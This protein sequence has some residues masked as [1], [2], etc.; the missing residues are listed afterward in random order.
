MS[1]ENG[2]SV[3]VTL[4]ALSFED[5]QCQRLKEMEKR[6]ED[7]VR[8]K[9]KDWEREVEL[10]RD[11]F[12]LLYP[13]DRVWGSEELLNDPLVRK[14]RGSTDIL[15]VKKMRTLFLEYPDTGRRYKLRFDVTSF[16]SK[17]VKVSTDGDRLIVRAYRTEEGSDGATVEREYSRKI[18]KPKDVDATKLRSF[19]TSD[20][21]LIVEAPVPPHSLNLRKLS[22]SPS[23]SSQGSHASSSRSRSPSNSPRT[24]NIALK[25]NV[26][27]FMDVNGDRRMNL[28]VDVGLIFKPKD[29]T[30]QIIKTNI[31]QVMAKHEERTSEKVSKSK[32]HREYELSEKIEPFTMRAGLMDSGRLLIGAMAKGYF[33][34]SKKEAGEKMAQDLMTKSALACNVLDLASFPP[35]AVAT[36]VNPPEPSGNDSPPPP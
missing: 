23:H 26:P 33:N 28:L 24:P 1:G 18:E 36:A 19:M 31:L 6:M 9:K 20:G 5:R 27:T 35:T 4:D 14:R 3:P 32:Y 16:D 22:H 10:M 30:V 34:G 21:V 25:V 12:L 2:V 13:S 29:I 17:R 8:R 11:E 7:E 15:D